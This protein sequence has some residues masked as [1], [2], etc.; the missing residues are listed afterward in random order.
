VSVIL[1]VPRV[2]G[3]PPEAVAQLLGQPTVCDDVKHGRLCVYD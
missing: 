2:A 1:D 3:Q